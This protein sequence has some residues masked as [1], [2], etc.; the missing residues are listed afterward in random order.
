MA[1]RAASLGLHLLLAGLAFGGLFLLSDADGVPANLSPSLTGTVDIAV[2]HD[3]PLGLTLKLSRLR[4]Q[5]LLIVSSETGSGSFL[6]S[7]PENW[8]RT[9]VRSAPL[10]EVFVE[11]SAVGFARWQIPRGAEVT[12]RLP[13]APESILAHHPSVSPL[14]ITAVLVDLPEETVEENVVLIQDTAT[15]LW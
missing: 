7:V 11:S 14:R 12:F 15:L 3:S 5:G 10:K 9:E 1:L 8:E 4:G 6:L 2:E 13:Q